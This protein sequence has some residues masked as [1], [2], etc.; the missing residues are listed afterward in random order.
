M[1]LLREFHKNIQGNIHSSSQYGTGSFAQPHTN[2][3]LDMSC[4]SL[5]L[6]PEHKIP[7]VSATKV[8]HH[9]HHHYNAS[10]ISTSPIINKNIVRINNKNTSSGS[11]SGDNEGEHYFLNGCLSWHWL[12]MWWQKAW[13]TNSHERSTDASAFS[14]MSYNKVLELPQ[15]TNK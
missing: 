12:F 2:P 5:L 10:S 13:L 3:I 1:E 11:E 6:R 4:S 14:V 9:Y 8:Y 15:C 7:S